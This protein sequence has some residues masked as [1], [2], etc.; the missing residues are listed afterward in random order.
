[1]GCLF[2]QREHFRLLSY[3]ASSFKR[4]S[5]YFSQG[6]LMIFLTLRSKWPH[7]QSWKQKINYY[8]C[9]DHIS[10]HNENELSYNAENITTHLLGE[11]LLMLTG[12]NGIFS[13]ISVLQCSFFVPSSACSNWGMFYSRTSLIE[14]CSCGSKLFKIFNW[15]ISNDWF[16]RGSTIWK[17]TPSIVVDVFS[18]SF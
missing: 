10:L 5:K 9:I 1:M 6:S 14:K 18:D 12:S 11:E 3:H 2:D 16:Y 8:L 7:L 17:G 15:T 13:S 4:L